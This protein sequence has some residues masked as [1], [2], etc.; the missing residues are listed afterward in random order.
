MPATR[1]SSS[2]HGGTRCPGC[3]L[4]MPRQP[5][6]VSHRYINASP[7]CWSVYTEVLAREYGD[8]VLFGA[9]HQLTVDA[10]TAQHPGGAHPDT[11]VAIHLVGLRLVLVD[12][13]P[14]QQI[15]VRRGL[16]S[17][18]TATWPRLPAPPTRADVTV[19][20]VALAAD[21]GYAAQVER[22]AEA[23]WRMWEPAHHVIA[24]LSA[25]VR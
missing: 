20:D 23:V 21:D 16:L 2:A 5:D 18:R 9:A 3:G 11:S 25:R 24:D 15:P 19:L 6:A 7:E 14:Q 8:A 17:D 1:Q 12:G 4:T 22:W 10:Y 13:L